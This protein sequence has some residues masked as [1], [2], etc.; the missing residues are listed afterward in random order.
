MREQITPQL[1]DDSLGG[2]REQIDLSVVE[3]RL[4]PE[5][6]EQSDRNVV[7]TRAISRD[8]RRVEQA[9]NDLWKRESDSN[10]E[11]KTEKRARE[12]DRVGADAGKQGAQW[13]RIR[14]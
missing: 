2:H 10:A 1:G 5:K 13:L 14:E 8:E 7:E 4:Y 12:L 11:Q 6:R 3:Y 9:P